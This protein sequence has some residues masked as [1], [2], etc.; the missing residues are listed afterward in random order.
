MGGGNLEIPLWLIWVSN[1]GPLSGSGT[2]SGG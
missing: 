2:V 1:F